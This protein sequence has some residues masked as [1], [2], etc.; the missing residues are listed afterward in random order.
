MYPRVNFNRLLRHAW[1]LLRGHY[2]LDRDVYYAV[3]ACTQFCL[4]ALTKAGG[5]VVKDHNRRKDIWQRN[6]ETVVLI[7]LPFAAPLGLFVGPQ[8]SFV[9]SCSHCSNSWWGREEGGGGL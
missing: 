5:L 4:L 7:P 9:L 8:I 6:K 2:F 1:L 3:F